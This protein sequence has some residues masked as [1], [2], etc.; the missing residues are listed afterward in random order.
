MVWCTHPSFRQSR[1][2]TPERSASL[3]LAERTN[4]VVLRAGS[5]NFSSDSEMKLQSV[6]SGLSAASS[7]LLRLKPCPRMCSIATSS[8]KASSLLPSIT[9]PALSMSRRTAPRT[10]SSGSASASTGAS[11]D[12]R[13]FGLSRRC[14][15]ASRSHSGVVRPS[16]DSDAGGA[17]NAAA[18]NSPREDLYQSAMAAPGNAA[19]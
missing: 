2:H 14:C 8:S 3:R 12:V 16:P 17:R 9:S 1:S 13:S 5:Q 15:S 19:E 4:A 11:L 18:S 10:V 6:R 7:V